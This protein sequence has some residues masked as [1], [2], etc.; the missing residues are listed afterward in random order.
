MGIDSNGTGDVVAVGWI[1]LLVQL[2]PLMLQL[3]RLGGM[4]GWIMFCV[5]AK[6]LRKDRD[7]RLS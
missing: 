5:R 6:C 4:G 1:W 3:Q 2:P 7:A